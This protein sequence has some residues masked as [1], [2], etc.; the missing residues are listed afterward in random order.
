MR[1]CHFLLLKWCSGQTEMQTNKPSIFVLLGLSASL[2]AVPACGDTEE[3][4]S[5]TTSGS[6]SQ[7][8]G[9]MAGSGGSSE[10]GGA[11]GGGNGGNGG[12]GGG[13]IDTSP[14]VAAPDAWTWV[15]FPNSRCNHGTPTGVGVRLRPNSDKLL[16]YLE[17]GGSCQTAESCWT[18][19]SAAN[20]TGYGAAE[21]AK[22]SKLTSFSLFSSDPANPFADMNM[23]FVPYCTGDYHSGTKISKLDV[24][25]VMTDTYF[26]GGKNMDLFISRLAP[27]FP[28]VK[29]AWLAGTSAGGAGTMLNYGKF[30]QAFPSLRIDTLNDSAPPFPADPAKFQ[31]LESLWGLQPP[32][33][34]C[35]DGITTFQYN[36]SLTPMTRSGIMSFAYDQTIAAGSETPL[37]DFP[38]ALE[39]M[40]MTLSS[41]PNVATFIANNPIGM[42]A[43]VITTKT[44]IPQLTTAS[45]AWLT[46]MV[47]D[48]PTWANKSVP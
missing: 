35:T 13:T 27:T 8:T 46:L 14:I 39:N 42:P 33:P 44:N 31:G 17:G 40:K 1:R 19:P 20:V 11:G 47:Q 32:C 4:P 2:L 12:S 45:L 26:M 9:G 34:T 43:H 6:S 24:N 15:D 41:D 7:G 25:G 23:V 18:N 16:V 37:A 10:T 3:K 36:R 48:D 21:F 5:S 28:N 22:E 38:A 30:K 29:R